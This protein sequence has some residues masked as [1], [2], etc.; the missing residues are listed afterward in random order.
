MSFQE[1]FYPESRLDGLTAID[2]TVA[3]YKKVN[4]LINPASVVLDLGCGR[5]A[6]GDDPVCEAPAIADIKRQMR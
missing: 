3:F 5:G 2:G 1:R 4:A 6:Y